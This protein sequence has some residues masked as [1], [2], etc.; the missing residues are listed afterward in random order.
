MAPSPPLI[1]CAL[2][3]PLLAYSHPCLLACNKVKHLIAFVLFIVL[4]VPLHAA[5]LTFAE[6]STNSEIWAKIIV[7]AVI[8][9]QAAALLVMRL[10]S[11]REVPPTQD[12]TLEKTQFQLRREI[13]RH[14][15]T[16]DLLTEA[17]EYLK[18][19][20]N[21]IPSI[22]IGLTE[23]GEVVHWN[24]GAFQ[25]TAVA[26]SEAE[27]Q[28]IHQVF[29]LISIPLEQIQH[30]IKSGAAYKQEA[31][32]KGDGIEMTY[33]D[34]VIQP[35]AS[36]ASSGAVILIQ[37]VTLRVRIERSMIQNEKM[38]SLGKMAA[39]LAHEINN[40]LAAILSNTQTIERRLTHKLD[41]NIK[42]ANT[43]DLDF[44]ALQRYLENRDIPDLLQQA[45]N[46]GERAATI[47]QTML[48]FS[49]AY[50]SKFERQDMAVLMNKSLE[51]A[52][53]TIGLKS[54]K[55]IKMPF[56][57]RDYANDLP[58]VACS[59][60][61]IQQVLLNLLLNAAQAIHYAEPAIQNPAINVRITHSNN[62]V[63]LEVSDNGPGMPEAV[64]KHIFE[65]FFTTKEVGSGTGLGLSVSYF[66]VS[67]H[68]Q[69]AIDV[70][71]EEG[72]G[73][74]FSITLPVEQPQSP[75]TQPNHRLPQERTAEP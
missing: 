9:T 43:C 16:G 49:H 57:I 1:A 59:A 6:G 36:P 68:H 10:R 32:P 45:H 35:L 22:V 66:I 53:N 62:T 28:H 11:S 34:L 26:P 56:V 20:I 5:P 24:D 51:L 63:T 71:S 23:D 73:T 64:L 7:S 61:E 8:L 75:I 42:H 69:G 55:H 58:R 21:S 12:V 29:Q 13:A 2:A 48:E 50:R 25:A 47:V 65:P 54:D 60:S 31:I 41:T 40:P 17:Q 18:S 30:T 72:K 4:A 70:E 46:A 52:A 39:G 44:S 3:S 38:F 37:D 33:W 74:H 19:L 14:E 67:D 27:G 15:N